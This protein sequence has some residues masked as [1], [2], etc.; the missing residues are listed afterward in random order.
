VLSLPHVREQ[1]LDI[2]HVRASLRQ[3]GQ[4]GLLLFTLVSG[5]AVGLGVPRLWVSAFAGAL[6][7]A[8]LGT[9]VG[10]LASMCGAIITFYIARLLLR[11]VLLRRMP[12]RLR[13]WYDRFNKHGFFWLFYIRLFPFANATV[14]NLV[15]GVSQVSLKTFL[16][17]TFLGYLP[18]TI[19][20]AVFG[21]SAAKS[22]YVQFAVALVAILIFLV[23]ERSWQYVRNRRKTIAEPELAASCESEKE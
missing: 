17:A 9:I 7:G 12:D 4:W 21:S 16:L 3:S 8:V 20:F 22:D 1:V 2:D 10:Q 19:I 5:L 11:S 18:E 13:V 14:T 15:G 23:F 6:F